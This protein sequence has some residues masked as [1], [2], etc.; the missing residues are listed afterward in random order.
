MIDDASGTG[1]AL[2]PRSTQPAPAPAELEEFLY[3]ITHD[4][5]AAFRAFQTIPEWIE[6]DMGPLPPDRATAVES[7]LAMLMTQARRCDRML[8]DLR[9]YSRVG[10]R[11]DSDDQ[12]GVE[13]L[14]T[15]ALS[16]SPLAQGFSL[17]IEGGGLLS[18]PGNELA[19]LFSALLSNAV[20]HHDRD[21]GKITLRVAGAGPMRQ[22]EFSDDGPGIPPQF[23]EAVFDPL[24]TLKPRDVCEGSGMGLAIARKIVTRLGGTISLAETEGT[25][26]TTVSFTLPGHDPAQ[27]ARLN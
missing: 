1:A 10:R 19:L 27:P 17:S 11:A 9:D 20:K 7:H 23:R 2:P 26:G 3:I 12:H 15:R 14:L 16:Q 4:L 18:G 8:L 6:E 24:R 21:R 5:R 22:L 25:R 13:D